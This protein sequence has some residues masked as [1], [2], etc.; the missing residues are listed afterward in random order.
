MQ[1]AVADRAS[2]DVGSLLD[3]APW[4][5]YQRLLVL[6]TAVTIIF[7]G[8]DLQ[9]FG[10]AIPVLMTEWSVPRGAFAPV[11]ASG[12]VGMLIGGAL[13]GIVGDRV[14]RKTALLGCVMWFGILTLAIAFANTLTAL[15]V[16]RF[17][18]GVGLGGA[19]PNAAALAAEYVPQRHRPLA[20]TLTIVCVPLGGTLAGLVASELLPA[21]GWRTLF[22]AGG[23]VPLVVAIALTRALP[24]SPRYLA[25]HPDRW[26]EL[27]RLLRRAGHPVPSGA[28][29]VDRTEHDLARGS[30]L[31]LVARDRRRDTLALWGAFFCCQVAVYVVFNWLT[32]LLTGAGFTLAVASRGFA[33]F[34]LGGV[35]GAILGG[36]VIARIGSR[37]TMIALAAGAAAGTLAMSTM[38][39]SSAAMTPVIVM[40][41]ITG[42]LINGAQTTLY[43]LA[44]HVYPTNVRATGVGTAI[45]VGRTGAVL[46]TYAGAWAL[47][48]GGHVLFFVLIAAAMALVVLAMALV[49]RHVP[50]RPL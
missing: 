20:V 3:H 32:S 41:A 26:A 11:L 5:G 7:D 18:A 40:L 38:A 39:L 19:L 27:A 17:L 12:L 4:G 36:L 48:T 37:P 21:S 50:S 46:S 6:L 9:L 15:A 28:A 14:G 16:L 29:F 13:A 30:I 35:V 2:V 25:R 1:D 22:A 24:E 49:Q 8:A 47:E 33:A 44:A 23:V 34:N 45:A 42:A 31:A 43:A 10:I